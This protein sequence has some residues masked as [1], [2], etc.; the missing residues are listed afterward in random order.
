MAEAQPT[1]RYADHDGIPV[2][3]VGGTWTV[4]S[5]RTL[6]VKKKPARTT[7]RAI[8]AS[9]VDRLDTAGVI[10]IL[11]LAGGGK[12][13]E[14]TTRDHN[15]AALFKVVQANLPEQKTPAHHVNWIVHWLDEAGH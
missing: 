8:D 3:E 9:K 15:H 7:A 6:Q 12:D 11:D 4:F 1:L 2:L 5:T 14:V 13:T 10:E